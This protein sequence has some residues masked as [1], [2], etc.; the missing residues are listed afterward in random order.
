MTQLK[1]TIPDLCLTTVLIF[2]RLQHPKGLPSWIGLASWEP[3]LAFHHFVPCCLSRAGFYS[4]YSYWFD[5]TGPHDK[6][7]VWRCWM[8]SPGQLA[9]ETS[10]D[11]MCKETCTAMDRKEAVGCRF[12]QKDMDPV[13]RGKKHTLGFLSLCPPLQACPISLMSS[14]ILPNNR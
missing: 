13:W 7:L 3:W 1:G 9:W 14:N 4:V 11:Q 12:L 6:N 8:R 5:I 2:I 10:V